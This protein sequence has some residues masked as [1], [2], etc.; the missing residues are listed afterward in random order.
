MSPPLLL[1]RVIPPAVAALILALPASSFAVT[2]VIG[3]P[4]GFGIDPTGLMRAGDG[5]EPADTDG[6]GILE[7]GEFLPDWNGDGT[8]ATGSGDDF[9]MRDPAEAADGTYGAAWTDRSW[10]G[11]G[12]A[13][14]ATFRF[15]FDVPAEDQPDYG[16]PH[17]IN[18]LF[19][20]YDAVPAEISIDDVIVPLT[21]QTDAA[22]G[23]IQ[24]AFT[25]VPWESMTDGE[26]T[27]TVHAPHEPY[28]AYDYVLLATS[29][30]ADSDG[31]GI[32]DALDNCPSTPNLVQ[33]DLDGD[34]VG[35]ACDSCPQVPNPEQTDSDA[36]GAGDLCDTCP[37]DI[38][39][40]ADGDGF[41]APDD[42][43]LSDA[44]I[45]PDAEEVCDE[46]DN[47][48]DGG[49]DNLGDFDNDG[50]GICT[51]CDDAAPF[52]FPGAPDDC[53]DGLD[54]DCDGVDPDCMDDDDSADGDDDDSYM[55]NPTQDCECS[56]A[57]G[58]AG[59]LPL[60]LLAIRRRRAA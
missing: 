48:C 32:P 16:L 55:P 35:S 53:E 14:N 3:D 9:N 29:R 51:D 57:G 39:D 11:L 31:D 33:W 38:T 50:A 2:V 24:A 60:L 28:M 47:D 8:V 17:Y 59:L 23:L 37:F 54:S 30:V 20:D 42:C 10:A 49:I 56:G 21:H 52:V 1:A 7:P 34:G 15:V 4:D 18:F 25:P 13:D 36:D 44:A 46:A 43:D 41:C 26:I 40:D 5:T 45:H 22:D 27:I 19:G 6:D 12:I 58:T